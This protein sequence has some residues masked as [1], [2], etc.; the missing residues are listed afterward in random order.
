MTVTVCSGFSRAGYREYGI[1]F[2]RTFDKF[3][4]TDVN[5]VV[6]AEEM[7]SMPRGECRSLWDCE[8]A[9]DFHDRHGEDGRRRG[10]T[11][12]TGWRAKDR[13]EGYAWRFDA[14][15]FYK[16]CIIPYDASKT[17]V[18]DD[19]LVWLDADVVTFAMVPTD[20]IMNLMGDTDLAFFGR[21]SYHSE[22]GFWS[23]RICKLS[24]RMLQ[25]FAEIYTNDIFLTLK[26]HHSAF[27][28]DHVRRKAEISGLR[29]KNLTPEGRNGSHGSHVWL[30]SPLAK[31][32]DHLKGSRRKNIGHSLDHPIRWWER[33]GR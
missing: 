19:I 15:K 32:T 29:T 1:N 8:G 24:R 20:F 21:G 4:P 10:T 7:V 5:L 30:A 17:L 16:Q 25:S 22:I 2:V 31:Y 12:I 18:Q 33:S 6:Y 26:E 13:N 11:P 27:V 14:A 23:I 3:W 28:F 9:R